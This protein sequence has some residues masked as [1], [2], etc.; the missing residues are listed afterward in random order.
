MTARIKCSYLLSLI[1]VPHVHNCKNKD[2]EDNDLL[3]SKLLAHLK[4]KHAKLFNVDESLGT[5]NPLRIKQKETEALKYATKIITFPVSDNYN[6]FI[7]I[8]I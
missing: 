8:V 7:E 4:Q 3:L 5:R 2:F 6:F 1:D